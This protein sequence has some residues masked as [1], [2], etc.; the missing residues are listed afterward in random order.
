MDLNEYF[1]NGWPK[2]KEDAALA[3]EV[4]ETAKRLREQ[5]EK[6]K[7]LSG[8]LQQVRLLLAAGKFE[9]AVEKLKG[10]L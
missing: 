4:V 5:T 7:R 1:I 3:K 8:R 10:M 6:C 2:T 9:E